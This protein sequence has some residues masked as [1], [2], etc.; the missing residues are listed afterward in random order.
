MKTVRIVLIVLSICNLNKT[1]A[2]GTWSALQNGLTCDLVHACFVYSLCA[3]TVNNVLY[4]GGT[5]KYAD[6]IPQGRIAKWDG[7]QWDSIP[8]FG[9]SDVHAL[10]MFKGNL[11][12]GDGYINVVSLFNGTSWSYLPAFN[13]GVTCLGIYKDTLYAGGDFTKSDTTALNYIAKWDGNKW[14][15]LKTGITGSFLQVNAMA[16]YHDTL[17]VGGYF[18]MVD[19]VPAYSIAKWDGT[20]WSAVGDNG[21]TAWSGTGHRNP[22]YVN[23]LETFQDN[24]YVGGLFDSAG[25]ISAEGDIVT[26]NGSEWGLL[27]AEVDNYI[28]ALKSFDGYLFLSGGAGY[29]NDYITKFDGTTASAVDSGVNGVIYSIT[30]WNGSLYVGGGFDTVAG[31]YDYG[32]AYKQ[33]PANAIASWTPDSTATDIKQIGINNE[34]VSVYPN[35]ASSQ[36]SVISNQLA[37]KEMT[38]TD[39]LGEIVYELASNNLGTK[40]TINVRALPD[41]LYFLTVIANSAT[42]TKKII[43]GR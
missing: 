42:I 3:D 43:I 12:V 17:F 5:F 35:P 2:Q 38:I 21:I 18:S 13:G 33:I 14:Q 31:C 26:W 32:T 25:G 37:I 28:T 15:P 19:T 34:L 23:A 30:D 4:A 40:Q 10:I 1:H 20:N 36:L 9:F 41:G 22:D 8:N 29:F 11:Y 24:L 39:L 7:T 6:S 27:P 16:V